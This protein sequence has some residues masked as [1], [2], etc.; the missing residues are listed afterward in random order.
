MTDR[1]YT[2]TLDRVNIPADLKALTDAELSMLADELRSEVVSAVSETGGHLGSSL[3][4]VELSVALHA[5]FNTPHDKLVWDVG[6]QCYPHKILTGR[7]DRIRTLR[8]EG[9]LSGFTKRSESEYDPFGAAHS[10]TSISAALGF[11]TARDLGQSTGDAIAVI[12]DGSI[13]AGM[14]YE[15]MNN[16]GSEGR[17]LFVILNDNEM[18]IAP[19]VGAMSRYLS[20]LGAGAFG[21]IQ[22]MAEGFEAA[23]P[24]PIRDH[25]RRARQLVTGA[26]GGSATLFEELGFQYM[27]P[28]DGHDMGQLLTVLRAARTRATGP[29][30]IHACTVK[31]KGYA[32][33]EGSDDKYHGVAKFNVATGVQAKSRPNAPSYTK[34]FGESLV[35]QAEL[36]SKIVGITAAMPSG[37]GIDIFEKVFPKRTFDVGIAEQ[38]AVTFAAG[39]AATG[40]K[41]FVAIY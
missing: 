25:A 3:G 38:H 11:A 15:A 8:Q 7:R 18:S 4:V 2:P 20:G 14:A 29:V 13:S 5:V 23:L 17:R 22:K 10:S 35:K 30:L 41:P 1:P 34:V 31:G 33:A 36:D 28:I 40:L 16:A 19:P 6:H 27:G 26:V 39:L 37:T 24:G 12:G 9:G 21:D 32:P